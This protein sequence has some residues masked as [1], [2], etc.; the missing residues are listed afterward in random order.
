MD[1][2]LQRVLER[3][4][5]LLHRAKRQPLCLEVRVLNGKLQDAAVERA[6]LGKSPSEGIEQMR[7]LGVAEFSEQGAQRVTVMAHSRGR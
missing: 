5:S 2:G 4:G 6:V 7:L 1:G 3:I